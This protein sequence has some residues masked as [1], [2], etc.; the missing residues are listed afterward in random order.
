[1]TDPVTTP[2]RIPRRAWF[3]F[4][5]VGACSFQNSLSLSIT[6]VAF[7]SLRNDFPDVRQTTLSWVLNLYTIA[8]AATLVV[9][10][11]LVDRLGRKRMLLT[12]T[13]TFGV[14]SLACA[15]APNVEILL[16]GRVV[17]AVASALVTPASVALIVRAFPDEHRATAVAGWA[18]VGSVAA[19]I[20]PALG[21]VLVDHGGWRWAFLANLPGGILGL[22]LAVRAVDESRDPQARPLPDLGGVALIVASVTLVVGGLV[23]SRAWGWD[24][25]RVP[26]AIVLGLALAVVLVR[27]SQ[28]HPVPIL[29]TKLFGLRSFSLANVGTFCFGIGF[30]SIFFGYVLFLTDVWHR[31]SR[32]AGL[33][34]TPLAI[35]GAVLAPLAGRVVRR[36]GPGLPLFVGGL[37]VTAG[38][39][40]LLV[41]ATAEPRVLRLWIPALTLV[42][43]GAG[44]VWPAIF[45]GLVTDVER[46]RYAVATGINQTVQRVATALGVAFAVMLLGPTKGVAGVG[47]FPRLFALSA[48]CGLATAVLA[49]V[50]G[51]RPRAPAT[52]ARG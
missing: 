6:N 24:D 45:A 51:L 8:A 4:A 18:A 42:G 26:A 44:V 48:A 12:G 30:F 2:V 21:G 16:V 25:R 43:C 36:R 31:S 15:A 35:C 28:R 17:Q 32:D 29:D 11:V 20:G 19:S 13:A 14:A 34:M 39:V 7:P 33:L 38:A 22:V 47:H 49:V 23:Q 9:A 52:P 3:A 37:L 40:W 41:G 10:G 27:R 1:M 50:I 5:A 46:E